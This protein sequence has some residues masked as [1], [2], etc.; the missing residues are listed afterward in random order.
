MIPWNLFYSLLSSSW[1][2]SYI[3][4][5]LTFHSNN[6]SS[7][8]CFGQAATLQDVVSCHLKYVVE[9][10]YTEQTYTAAQPTPEQRQAWSTTV[11]TLLH[12]DGNCT[13]IAASIPTPLQGLYT[14][15]E[16]TEP[17]GRSF[18]IFAETV[19]ECDTEYEKGWGI[20]VVPATRKA[21]SRHVHI[22]APH[23]LYDLGTEQQAAS[24]FKSIGA[25]SLYIPGR[26]RLAFPQLTPCVQSTIKSKYYKTDPAHDKNANGGCPAASCA[27]VQFHGKG[28]STCRSDHIFIST[29]LGRDKASREWYTNNTNY[30]VK[31]LKSQ[32]SSV[33]PSWTISLPTDSTCLLTAT[34]NI[35]GRLINGVPERKV[36]REAASAASAS[37]EFVHMEQAKISRSPKFYGH[38]TRGLLA[39]FETTCAGGMQKDNVTGLCIAM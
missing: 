4:S 26:M 38:W 17:S 10:R 3:L 9:T 27:Y 12:V 29:G 15:F 14:I 28:P 31:R 34:K 13:D 37:G 18:C 2:S 19:T 39:A 35:V 8:T 32:L 6:L 1:L 22:A 23:P 11:S 25:K 21:V 16:L 30:P 33:F 5:P 36:C 20:L 7:D 24:V